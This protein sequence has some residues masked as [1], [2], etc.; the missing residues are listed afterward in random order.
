ME[1]KD[2]LEANGAI[3]VPQGL[4]VTELSSRFP[5]EGGIY[6][7]TKR[8]LGERH[9]YVCGW[10]YWV[11]NLLYYPNLLISTAVVSA[12]GTTVFEIRPIAHRRESGRSSGGR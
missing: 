10:C 4:V 2:L 11:N 7:W 1:R 5:Q 3:F 8:A 6:Q 12:F 9:G